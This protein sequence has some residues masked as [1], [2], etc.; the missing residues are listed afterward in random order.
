[1]TIVVDR[2]GRL[3][4][5]I[6]DGDLRRLLLRGEAVGTQ[7]AGDVGTRAPKTIE[8]EAMA[9]QALDVME[10]SGPITSLVVIDEMSRP[11]GVVHMHHI[12]RAKV[13]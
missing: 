4:G 8:A 3:V 1:M 6:T 5:V 10:A 9:A 7:R 11:V 2:T 13:V 12:L